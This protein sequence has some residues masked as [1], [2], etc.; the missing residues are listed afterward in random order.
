MVKTY[1]NNYELTITPLGVASPR[2]QRSGK[3]F[4]AS[5]D[6]FTGVAA[7]DRLEIHRRKTNLKMNY[8]LLSQGSIKTK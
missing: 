5:G 7:S 6:R 4:F 2:L 8:K 1:R 3:I